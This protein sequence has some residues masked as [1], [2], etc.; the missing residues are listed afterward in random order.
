MECILCKKETVRHLVLQYHFC[1]ECELIFSDSDSFVSENEEKDVYLLHNNT[2]ECEGYV[3]MFQSFIDGFITPFIES[4][5]SLDYGCGPG[6]DFVLSSMLK[7]NGFSGDRYDPFFSPGR[8]YLNNKY[9]L[10]TSTEVFEHFQN[11][12]DGIREI[13]NLMKSGGILGIM[14]LFHDIKEASEDEGHRFSKWWYHRDP[15]HLVF[16]N[17]RT[18]E[19]VAE[20]FNLEIVACDEKRAV[21]FRKR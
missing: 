6:P 10:I 14:T 13:V 16:F 7:Q 15:T 2:F 8:E 3:K 18:I 11:P 17:R 9:D 21:T 20:I 4:G 5:R 1:S 12:L 19:K